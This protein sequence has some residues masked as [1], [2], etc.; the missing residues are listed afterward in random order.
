VAEKNPTS[1]AAAY[2]NSQIKNQRKE[3]RYVR[4]LQVGQQFYDRYRLESDGLYMSNSMNAGGVQSRMVYNLLWSNVQTLKPMLYSRLPEPFVSRRNGAGDPAA[5]MASQIAERSVSMDLERD[6]FDDQAEGVALDYAITGRGTIRATYNSTVV[7]SRIPINKEIRDGEDF[8]RFFMDNGE[9]IPQDGIERDDRGF[10]TLD[11]QTTDER[12][13]LLYHNWKD[14]LIGPGRKWSEVQRNGWI[15]YRTYMTKPEAAK[16]FGK[17][18]AN[19]LSYSFTPY[20]LDTMGSDN[21]NASIPSKTTI[22]LAEIWEIWDAAT[23]KVFWISEGFPGLLD[24]EDDFLNLE[25]FFNTPRPLMGT[26]TNDTLTPIPDYAEYHSQATELDQ[27]TAKIEQIVEDIYVGGVY[28]GNVPD[29]GRALRD[30]NGGWYPSDNFAALMSSGGI[31]G[32][33]QELDVAKKAAAVRDLYQHRQAVK[34]D[35]DE[36]SGIIDLHRGQQAQR[37]ET[38]GQSEIRSSV[39]GLRINEKQRDF[40]RYMRDALRLKSQIVVDKFDAERLLEMA[41]LQ[42]LLNQ[43]SK[44]SALRNMAESQ[45]G[46]K[47][48]QNPQALQKFQIAMQTAQAE[49]MALINQAVALL[50]NDRMRSFKLDIETD[51]T[52]ALDEGADQ[53]RSVQFVDGLANFLERIMNS[54]AVQGNPPLQ[55]LS[56]EVL[57]FLVRKAHVGRSLEEKIEQAIQDMVTAPPQPAKP[58]PLEVAAQSQAQKNQADVVRDQQ[59]NRIDAFEAETD[60][61]DTLIKARQTQ[62]DAV[63]AASDAERKDLETANKILDSEDNNLRGNGVLGNA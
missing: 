45:Q 37:D 38:L 5:R 16:R 12:A 8:P 23:R 18:A 46:Q 19:S 62:I 47:Q 51:A 33:V 61:M 39:G 30:K 59:K 50:K 34:A 54:P 17:N 40:Q 10:F 42:D 9:E 43:S 60:R 41:D 6:D 56:G 27:I 57:M 21:A 58:D 11:P 20:R 4:W 22:K 31:A 28:D 44:V 7:N 24:E 53:E 2:W 14:F 1:G 48:L 49:Q 3:T 35:A 36:M 25:G 55:A 26:F 32:A 29:L 15:G 63:E 52:V 13:P